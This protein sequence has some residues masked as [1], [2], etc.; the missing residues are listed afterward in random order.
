MHLVDIYG[1]LVYACGSF[2]GVPVIVVPFK[3]ALVYL[4]RST[5]AGLEVSRIGVSLEEGPAVLGLYAVFVSIELF[6]LGYLCFPD[7]VRNELAGILAPVPAVEVADDRNAYSIRSP[8]S[9]SIEGASALFS[10]VNA[11]KFPGFAVLALVKQIER[12][13]VGIIIDNR[14]N[15]ASFA[16]YILSESA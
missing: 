14:H 1:A 16:I 8:N 11:E 5:R 13:I 2:F 15:S 6:Q 9:E 7:A 4:G 10:A 12:K 3:A